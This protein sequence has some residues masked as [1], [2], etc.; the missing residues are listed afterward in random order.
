[1]L[2]SLFAIVATS[3]LAQDTNQVLV[4]FRAF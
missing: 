3:P 2:F 4:F 1:M